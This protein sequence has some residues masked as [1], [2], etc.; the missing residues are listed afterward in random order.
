MSMDEVEMRLTIK[1]MIHAF[2]DENKAFEEYTRLCQRCCALGLQASSQIRMLHTLLLQDLRELL[3]LLKPKISSDSDSVL[4][5]I[6]QASKFSTSRSYMIDLAYLGFLVDY[7]CYD[8][9]MS[10]TK[11]STDFIQS[12]IELTKM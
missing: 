8:A 2:K 9:K 11:L 10:N 12:V 4:E 3:D 6:R 1:L 5:I 7:F